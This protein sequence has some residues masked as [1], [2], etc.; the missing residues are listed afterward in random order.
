MANDHYINE[1][2]TEQEAQQASEQGAWEYEAECAYKAEQ[3]N[4][5]DLKTLGDKYEYRHYDFGG[6]RNGE[7][8][9]LAQSKPT[10]SFTNSSSKEAAPF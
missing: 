9:Q 4:L 1:F 5:T 6:K 3:L 8:N 7:I 10:A 2:E